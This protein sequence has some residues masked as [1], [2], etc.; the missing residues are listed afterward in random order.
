MA[1]LKQID[2][3]G[4]TYN[5]GGGTSKYRHNFEICLTGFP[6]TNK[7]EGSICFS[8]I[9]SN[10]P[11]YYSSSLFQTKIEAAITGAFV[12]ASGLLHDI[13]T[14]STLNRY[15]IVTAI[16]YDGTQFVVRASMFYESTAQFSSTINFAGTVNEKKLGNDSY[17]YKW[18]SSETIIS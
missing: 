14:S 8:V 15:Y 4:T 11:T 18:L 5:I 3:N 6:S 1:D 16:Q 2:Y 13:D 17:T 10:S 7:Y 9:N 12:P